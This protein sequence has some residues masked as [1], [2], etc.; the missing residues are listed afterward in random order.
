MNYIF[1]AYLASTLF[2]T[3][4]IWMVQVVHYPLMSMVGQSQFVEYE[5]QHQQLISLI[6]LPIMLLE[7]VTGAICTLG[8]THLSKTLLYF[9][10]ALL[11]L[12]CCSTFF[13]QVPLHNRL[14]QGFDIV[15]HQKLVQTN[16]IRTLFWTVKSGLL[17]AC[18][19]YQQPL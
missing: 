4:L 2:M 11:I 18:L 12:I 10:F 16:W 17:L 19:R 8:T 14:S 7:L 15:A 6:V 3:G 1:I 5:A 9:A 13:L